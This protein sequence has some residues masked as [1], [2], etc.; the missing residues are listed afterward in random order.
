LHHADVTWE[1]SY[2]FTVQRLEPDGLES[3]PNDSAVTAGVAGMGVP[4]AGTLTGSADVDWFKVSLA[5]AQVVDVSFGALDAD[6]LSVPTNSRLTWYLQDGTT[7]IVPA[8]SFFDVPAGDTLVRVDGYDSAG[9][10]NS[11]RLSM[12]SPPVTVTST[13]G[14]AFGDD[15]STVTDIINVP[16]A[17]TLS[18]PLII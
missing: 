13:P 3:E 4:V 11:Y 5:E 12:G 15:P 17:C 1:V 9:S 14:L 18:D 16:T 2:N 6:G 10:G 8:G 7:E